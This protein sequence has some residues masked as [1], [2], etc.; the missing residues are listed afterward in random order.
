MKLR[1][2]SEMLGGCMW[3]PRFIDKARLHLAGAL[4]TDYQGAFCN[5]LGMDGV[6]LSHFALKKNELLELIQRE[7]T[8]EAVLAWWVARPESSAS[9][10]RAWNEL[11]PNVG[12]PGYPNERMFRWAM[13]YVY[14]RC[15]DARVTSGF[16]A[17]AWDEG[18]LDE[19][20]PR[21]EV[22]G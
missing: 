2:P 8:D 15:S 10:I 14:P 5:P 9:A 1:R 19:V 22:N 18:F 13:K 6:F 21:E 12:K 20:C 11:A 17:I 7:P 16:L 3:L 4:P